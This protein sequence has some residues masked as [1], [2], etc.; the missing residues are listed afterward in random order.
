[1]MCRLF[2]IIFMGVCVCLYVTYVC[3]YLRT[4][5]CVYVCVYICMYV[6]MYV[7][8]VCTYVCMCVYAYMCV[9]N[10]YTCVIYAHICTHRWCLFLLLYLLIYRL[11]LLR[12]MELF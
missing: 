11:E 8:I 1:M 4:Y 12:I 10:A 9:C 6:C 5:M 2:S 3:V 7:C